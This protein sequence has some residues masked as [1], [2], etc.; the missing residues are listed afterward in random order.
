[1]IIMT[2]III[3]INQI[4]HPSPITLYYVGTKSNPAD[5]PTRFTHQ[6]S[7][8]ISLF[9]DGHRCVEITLPW[10]DLQMTSRVS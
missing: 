8:P 9:T 2:E 10:P 4:A 1:V 6:D 7:R 3:Q 5:L